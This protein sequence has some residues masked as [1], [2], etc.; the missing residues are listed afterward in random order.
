MTPLQA[1]ILGII[2][3]ATEFLP[4][5][6]SGHLVLVPWLLNWDLDPA[7]AFIF[8]VL[9]QWG[10]ILAVILY[11]RR[12]LLSMITAVLRGI[13][14]RRPFEGTDARLAWLILLASV[15]AAVLGLLL[16]PAIV[17]AFD[18][19][20]AVSFFLLV[21]AGL[22]F[23]SERLHRADKPMKALNWVDSLWIG[24][25][26]ALALFPGISRSG[27]TIAGGLLRSLKRED[28]ARF[29][30]LLAIPTMLGAGT[31]ALLDLSS[32]PDPGSQ[33][34]SLFIGFASAAIV[35]M[36]TIHWLLSY[37]RRH[38]LDIFAIYCT[39]V[40]LGGLILYAIKG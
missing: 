22:L 36:A 35:G 37:L 40:G 28:A 8:N 21:T 26:Q 16:K 33:L 24:L 38:S 29:S 10:T 11:F 3:G 5:S 9:V 12:E 19:P 31:I 14:R 25:A 1:L 18:S 7:T 20:L 17:K 34:L 4:I 2:Q 39:V 27:S 30:F 6:S 13:S 23:I 32:I 15:P